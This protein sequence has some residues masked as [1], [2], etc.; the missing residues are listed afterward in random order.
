MNHSFKNITAIYDTDCIIKDYYRIE[1]WGEGGSFLQVGFSLVNTILN[2]LDKDNKAG[3]YWGR[4]TIAGGY[5]EN[6]IK[7]RYAG[8]KLTKETKINIKRASSYN[9]LRYY[10]VVLPSVLLPDFIIR[11]MINFKKILEKIKLNIKNKFPQ[12]YA[13]LKKLFNRIP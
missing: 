1:R 2:N 10:F 11:N 5:P 3:L 8:L 13:F 6:I 4:R 9:M 7:A 12:A